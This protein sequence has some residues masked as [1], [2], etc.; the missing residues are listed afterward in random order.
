[1]LLDQNYNSAMV[2]RKKIISFS[3][4]ECKKKMTFPWH[5]VIDFPVTVPCGSIIYIVD[6]KKNFMIS[7]ILS[8]SLGRKNWDPIKTLIN[9]SVEYKYIKYVC[10]IKLEKLWEPAL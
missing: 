5:W 10:R 8:K 1:M 2:S 9:D 7:T 6:K 3:G 4:L